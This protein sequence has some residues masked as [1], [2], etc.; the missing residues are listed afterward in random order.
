[1]H[2]TISARGLCFHC[3]GKDV[4]EIY[5]GAKSLKPDVVGISG[6]LPTEMKG[7][8]WEDIED[9]VG[10]KRSVTEMVLQSET[11]A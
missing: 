5:G 3:F 7:L 9:I 6:E 10:S 4:K 1:M 2:V 11:Y 8:S